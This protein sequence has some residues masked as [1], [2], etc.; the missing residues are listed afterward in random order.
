M[1]RSD[2]LEEFAARRARVAIGTFDG[3]HLG[4]RELIRRAVERAREEGGEAVALTFWPHPAQVLAPAGAPRLLTGREERARRIASLGVDALFEIP[5]SPGVASWPAERFVRELLAARLDVRTVVVGYNFTFGR[6]AEGRPE[7]LRRLGGELGFETVVVEPVCEGGRPVSSSRIRALVAAGEVAEAGRLLGAP[8]RLE[9]RVVPGDRRGRQLG[10]PTANLDV[11]EELLR[12]ARG[13]YAA[14]AEWQPAEAPGGA[15]AR[16]G[17]PVRRAPAVV[18]VG[19]RPT[20][21]GRREVVEAHLPGIEEDLY[22]VRLSL[23]LVERLREERRFAGAEE[24]RRQIAEDVQAARR[25]L[26]W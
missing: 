4:H 14:W 6:G 11:P 5:F 22:G 19:I 20:F 25:R 9:G 1:R 17:R 26:A 10:F 15:R 13:V 16:E 18:N 2:R 8:F 23:D 3:V 21:D 24:L 7:T 12:P